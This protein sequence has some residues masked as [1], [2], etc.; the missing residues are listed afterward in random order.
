MPEDPGPAHP[1]G[2]SRSTSATVPPN[3]LRSLAVV[4][5]DRIDLRPVLAG[6][7]LSEDLLRSAAL[8]VSYRQG[9]AVIH[10]VLETTGDA[11]LGLRA[12]A[13]QHPTSWGLLGF[14]LMACDTV[15]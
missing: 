12:G 5:Q 9:A 1:A 7:G 4:T 14:A 8:R 13:A 15:E 10:R 6:V 2:T 3:I 11:H